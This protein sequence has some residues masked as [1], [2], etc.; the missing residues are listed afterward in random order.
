MAHCGTPHVVY[1][2]NHTDHKLTAG[3]NGADWTPKPASRQFHG[4]LSTNCGLKFRLAAIFAA[5]RGLA[6]LQLK[7]WLK[8]RLMGS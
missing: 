8:S 1:I 6:L 7:F 4:W 2:I 3:G 5:G